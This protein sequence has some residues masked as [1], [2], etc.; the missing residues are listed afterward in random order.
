MI[1][2]VLP[3]GLHAP[4]YLLISGWAVHDDDSPSSLAVAMRYDLHSR[5]PLCNQA[6]GLCLRLHPCWVSSPS[7][8]WLSHSLP[9]F[10]G[11]LPK[12]L[13]YFCYLVAR[14]CLTLLQPHGLW[15]ARL[16][17]PWDFPG[18]NT[19]VGC[20]FLLQGTESA[21]PALAGRFFITEPLNK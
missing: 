17:C 9:S 12:K 19:G 7:W 20:H 5:V 14:L 11:R 16:L 10:P 4:W 18:K 6:I 13:L 21:S 15:R 1:I 8:S 3:G 2:Q